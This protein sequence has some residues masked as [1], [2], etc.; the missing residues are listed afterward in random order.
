VLFRGWRGRAKMKRVG[1]RG[2]EIHEFPKKADTAGGP[3]L[4]GGSIHERGSSVPCDARVWGFF[5]GKRREKSLKARREKEG[6]LAQKSSFAKLWKGR[7]ISSR[8]RGN[9]R[10]PLGKGKKRARMRKEERSSGGR[11]EKSKTR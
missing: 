9:R 11:G 2:K 4:I 3:D 8:G 10:N 1:G 7:Y 6:H 5:K